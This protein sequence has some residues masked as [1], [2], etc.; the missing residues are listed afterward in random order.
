MKTT[1]LRI[2][3]TLAILVGL[4]AAP[5]AQTFT[6]EAGRSYDSAERA[7]R[8]AEQVRR[9]VERT[10]RNAERAVELRMRHAERAAQLAQR[11]AERKRRAHR[12]SGH[13]PAHRRADPQ[14][15]SR[16]DSPQSRPLRRLQPQRRERRRADWAATPIPAATTTGAIATTSSTAKCANRRCRPAAECRCGQERWHLDRGMGSQRDSRPRRSSQ[17]S[18]REAA[19]S[20]CARRPG[21][22]AGRRRPR[23]CDRS[24]QHPPR[25]VVGQLPHQRAAQ[26][27]PRSP[28]QQRRHHHPRRQRQHAL[29]HDQRRREAA[30]RR[31]PRQRR[32][33]AT[34]D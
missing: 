1:T 10:V 5:G 33:P 20:A 22:G 2:L 8:I 11:N 14:P 32:R 9:N 19:R 13:A 31:R 21:A 12:A 24:R 18:A 34:A 3:F 29:R 6:W 25:M 15:D 16:R 23:L 17:A 30:G 7:E 27:R 4:A 26:E 28:R